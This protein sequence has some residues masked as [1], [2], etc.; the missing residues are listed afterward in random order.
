[1][2]ISDWSSDVCSSDL[3]AERM[4]AAY[5]NHPSFCFFSLGNE[6]Q[7]DFDLLKSILL[8]LK[9]RDPRHLYTTTTFT[10]QKG[11][12]D[13]PEPQDDFFVTQWT[14]KGVVRGQGIFN[15]RYPDFQTDYSAAIDSTPVPIITHEIGQY[16]VYPRLDEIEKYTGVLEPL[17][18][19]A[20]RNDL[21]RKE[22]LDYADD[23]TLA[24]GKL[25]VLLYKEEIERALKTRDL[26]GFQLLDLHD[27]P[28]QGT[29]LVGIL[30]S[31]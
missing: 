6:L 8:E 14:H 31:F 27:F 22:L 11:H 28:G 2:R 29:A 3:E 25:A 16:S 24:S 30:D 18:F 1:M 4:I 20:V 10:F 15:N 7:G 13:W 9:E 17:N 21:K 19:M 5:G 26:S 23:F 12:G